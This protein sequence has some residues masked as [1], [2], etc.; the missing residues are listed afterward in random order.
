MIRYNMYM[1]QERYDDNIPIFRSQI[2]Y[3]YRHNISF[4]QQEYLFMLEAV[5]GVKPSQKT[6]KRI[7]DQQIKH[8]ILAPIR[9]GC[10]APDKTARVALWACANCGSQ[11]TAVMQ[12]KKCGRC[13]KV[14]YCSRACQRQHWKEHKKS[15]CGDNK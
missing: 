2:D 14:H 15:G 6:L 10:T 8:M 4:E 3:E 12:Y 1:K 11:E 13:E 7:T 9:M 5:M